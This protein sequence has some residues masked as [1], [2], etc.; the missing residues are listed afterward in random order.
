ML[1]NDNFRT[2]TNLLQMFHSVNKYLLDFLTKEKILRSCSKK[3]KEMLMIKMGYQFWIR[4]KIHDE[5]L[6]KDRE[7]LMYV[8]TKRSVSCV[9]FYKFQNWLYLISCC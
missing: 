5:D 1:N 9:N 2:V 6:Q 8:N 4:W 3:S 7:Q